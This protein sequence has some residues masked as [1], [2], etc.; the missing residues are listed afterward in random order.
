MSDVV[1][2]EKAAQFLQPKIRREQE[3]NHALW[4]QAD[5][6]ARRIVE[7]IAKSHRPKRIWQWGSLIRPEYFSEISD[8][9]I[10]L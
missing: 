7:Q 1:T 10:A 8:I 9:D 4:V 5:A 3:R 6:D 2:P